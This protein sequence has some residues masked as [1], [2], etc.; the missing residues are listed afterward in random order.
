MGSKPDGWSKWGVLNYQMGRS[1]LDRPGYIWSGGEISGIWDEHAQYF[2]NIQGD[3]LIE[4]LE[5]F[6]CGRTFFQMANRTGEGPAGVGDLTFRNIN[7]QDVC[8]QDGGGGS[9]FSF[10]GRHTGTILLDS[11]SVYLGANPN[12]HSNRSKNI[13]GAL[14]IH[15]GSETNGLPNGD[16]I[17]Q[18]CDFQVGPHFT[19]EG[20]ARRGNIQVREC[21]SFSLL[22]SRVAQLGDNPRE[23]LDISPDLV[24]RTITLDA[25]N[26]IIGE[27][28]WD[29]DTFPDYETMLDAIKSDPK[30][31]IQ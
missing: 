15:A 2:H 8:L 18:D 26:D 28:I 16:V 19:G 24:T 6:W 31:V 22:S 13:T 14:V 7:V 23:A 9:A 10:N 3:I 29:G 12:L 5:S 27:C 1:A 11:V 20:S 25:Q 21:T 17:V 4:N 30:V